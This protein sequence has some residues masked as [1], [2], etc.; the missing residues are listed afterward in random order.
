MITVL[1][2]KGVINKAGQTCASPPR[3]LRSL[4]SYSRKLEKFQGKQQKVLF[5]A[6]QRGTLGSSG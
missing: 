1:Y 5:Y 4:G 3:I 2:V 6:V